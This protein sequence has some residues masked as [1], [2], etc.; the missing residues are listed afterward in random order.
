MSR[1]RAIVRSPRDVHR[2]DGAI[3]AAVCPQGSRSA[4]RAGYTSAKYVMRLAPVQINAGC[5]MGEGPLEFT[6]DHPVV[7]PA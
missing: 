1:R 4:R 5:C 6:R 3:Q 2:R 7:Q